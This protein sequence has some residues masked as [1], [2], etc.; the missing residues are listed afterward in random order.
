MSQKPRKYNQAL[1]LKAYSYVRETN[2]T[3]QELYK[4]LDISHDT[5]NEW[6]KKDGKY[7]KSDLSDAISRARSEFIQDNIP[8]VENALLKKAT[9]YMIDEKIK[10][11]KVMPDGSTIITTRIINKHIAPSD[12]AI[13]YFLQN[14]TQN[15]WLNSSQNII[16]NTIT[17]NN[18]SQNIDILL[19]IQKL[20]NDIDNFFKLANKP[21]IIN[22]E[23]NYIH[24]E[25]GRGGGKSEQVARYVLYKALTYKEPK[26]ILCGREIQNSLKDSVKALLERLINDYELNQYF[27]VIREEIY[28]SYTNVKIIFMG[29]KQGTANNTDTVK[30]TDNL[31]L[32][33]IEEAQTISE[34]TMD[35]VIPT[36][37]RVKGFQIIFTYNRQRTNTVVYD[38]HLNDDGTPKIQN[39]LHIN[40][41]YWDN[42]YNTKELIDLAEFDKIN[43]YRKWEWVWAGKPQTI[44]DGA[45]WTY[46][47]IKSM[48]LNISY[49][50]D[51]YIKRIVAVDPAMSSKDFNN[52]YGI[53]ILGIN[54][55]GFV[56]II[57][58]YSGHYTATEFAKKTVQAYMVYECEACVYESNQGGEH[59]ANTI[60]SE[61]P[62]INLIEVRASS[63][64][65]ERAL[66]IANLTSQGKIYSI[67]RFEKL[68]SQMLLLTT[69]GY[70][71]AQGESPDRLDAFVWG[72]Y[73][74]FGLKDTNTQDVYFKIDYF[75]IPQNEKL[76]TINNFVYLSVK[77]NKT[78]CIK[79][80]FIVEGYLHRRDEH[81]LLKDIEILETG[82]ILDNL[83]LD[84][85]KTMYVKDDDVLNLTQVKDINI[86]KVEFEKKY[87]LIEFAT[88]ILPY[89]Q[90]GY[91]R[92]DESTDIKKHLVKYITQYNPDETKE[93]IVLEAFAELICYG[94]DILD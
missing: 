53:V 11:I 13:Q 81:L 19:K 18:N 46:E 29:L 42:K 34:L 87:N 64:K 76:Y 82:N 14:T 4:Y 47:A 83:V 93:N 90:L 80:D 10:D 52:E 23:E 68:E 89:I 77:G 72:C 75:K 5:L 22:R 45:L 88:K 60:L 67:K 15:K 43:N 36:I 62:Y 37:A 91:I 39:C 50:K 33:W 57:D 94:K 32:V 1:L 51:N 21:S 7:F 63:S 86:E 44:F 20:E 69:Q 58:D 55:D 66:P 38:Y 25:G 59:V 30:S 27:K 8:K 61:S 56:H 9:G 3:L 35:K 84:N 71:G 31:G 2:C 70:Q 16:N 74:L 40:I 79:A 28:C 48:C 85:I 92:I 12:S 24:L 49:E 41:N 73:E 26:T 54:K 78:V 6:L 17:Q 65:Y